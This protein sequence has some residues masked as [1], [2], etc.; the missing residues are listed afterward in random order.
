M[1][2]QRAYSVIEIKSLDEE[3]RELIGMATTP[4]TDLLDDIVEPKGG[5][6]KL[7]LPLLWQHDKHQ[8]IG[9]VTHAKASDNGI[10]IRAVLAKIEEPGRLKERLDEAWQSLKSGLVRGLSIG[11]KPLE[12][13]RI[14]R[15]TGRRFKR[16]SL[17]EV[18][19]VTIAANSEASITAIRSI[20]STLRAASGQTGVVHLNFPGVAGTHLKPEEGTQVDLAKNITAFEAKLLATRE[21]MEALTAKAVD[22]GRTFDASEQEEFDNGKAECSKITQHL[23]NLHDMESLQAVKAR[24][25]VAKSVDEG[26]RD[27]DIAARH[28]TVE[29][30]LPKGIEFAR[31]VRCLAA[32]KGNIMG[33][34]KVA[35]AQ[36]P[37]NP[38]IHTV[39]KAAVAAGTTTDATW[40][41]PFVEYTTLAGEFIEWLRPQT[42]LGKFGTNGI[43]ALNATPFNVRVLTQTS[44]GEGYWVGEGAAKPLTSFNFDAITLGFAKVA[45]IAVLTQELVR[46]S[47]PSADARVRQSLAEALRARLDID[48]I[49]PDK[50]EV[51]GVSPASITNGITPIAS[52]GSSLNDVRADVEALFGAFIADNMAPT[53]GVWI[54]S[55][56]TA[57][58]L[59]MMHNELGQTPQGFGNVTMNG[60]SFMGLPVIVSEH[61]TGD[62]S[63]S[64]LV[65]VNANDIMLADD[66]TVTIDA[67]TQASLEML[68]NPTGNAA[69][70]TATTLV[71]LWQTNCIGLKAERFINWRRAR[72]EAVQYISG[73]NYTSVAPS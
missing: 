62:S 31:Y 48:F 57:L 17:L 72:D 58:A 43:P 10:E 15:S 73:V 46:F 37:D 11:F 38:R 22:E 56:T 53:S 16:W 68:D 45:N 44:G 51:S 9:H 3:R 24:P 21:S 26:M 70:G 42:I 12:S 28:I 49:D 5:E 47:S 13:E 7:P 59:S 29:S 19:T 65:L 54:M 2:M 69:T 27:R 40:A 25:V 61:V 36:Y 41:G 32:A 55:A 63:G 4:A 60:G 23:A 52:S 66:G 33:A 8:P 6:F 50:A 1:N 39:L 34:L 14:E 35:E 18:S 20:D 64:M 30:P 71:S 67:S